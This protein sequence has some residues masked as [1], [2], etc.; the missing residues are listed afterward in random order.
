MLAAMI[1]GSLSVTVLVMTGCGP[2][3][4]EARFDSANPSAKLYAIEKAARS[5]DTSALPQL[6][7]QL[8]SDD[9]AVRLMA[10][11]A[12]RRLTGEDHGYCHDDPALLRREA[13][14]RWVAALEPTA[15]Q[16]VADSTSGLRYE[17]P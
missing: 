3:A 15:Q 5:G 9:P 4:T 1:A 17:P 8:D 11:E 2:P 12:L 16:R 14:K 10:I 6:V 7:E 13:I